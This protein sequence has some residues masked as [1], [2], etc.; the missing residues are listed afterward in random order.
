M[1]PECIQQHRCEGP[2]GGGGDTSSD[3]DEPPPQRPRR[4]RSD[5][6]R[7]ADDDLDALSAV[8]VSVP[9]RSRDR[10]DTCIDGSCALDKHHACLHYCGSPCPSGAQV[11]TQ[12]ARPA[13]APHG[14]VHLCPAGSGDPPSAIP[15]CY[16]G[17][18][19]GEMESVKVTIFATDKGN[20]S[21]KL[22]S[23]VPDPR[24]LLLVVIIRSLGKFLT[25]VDIQSTMLAE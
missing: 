24:L 13:F 9:K 25:D 7:L 11:V 21:H 1:C 22:S 4:V 18:G 15:H 3:D 6:P 5:P 16:T 17:G 19:L 14:H 23:S 12:A 20:H 10:C 8:P 2:G